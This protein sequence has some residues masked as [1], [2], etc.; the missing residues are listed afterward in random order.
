MNKNHLLIYFSNLKAQSPWL[1]ALL[2]LFCPPTHA[3]KHVSKDTASVVLARIPTQRKLDEA[4]KNTDYQYG[5]DIQIGETWWD[6]LQRKFWQWVASFFGDP[7]YGEI[8]RWLAILFLAGMAVFIILKLLGVNIVGLTGK[9]GST[10]DIPYEAFGENIHAINYQE[11][12]ENAIS[13]KNYRLAVRLYYLKTLKE[14]TDKGMIEWK[15]NK[16]NRTYLVELNKANLKPA[17]EQIT[18]Q[19]EYAWYGD[20]PIDE[21]RFTIIREDFLNFGK[22]I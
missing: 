18:Q 5:Q 19:F 10:L 13:Q 21:P 22:T 12:I 9:K 3:Q 4:K 20:F 11:A 7:R 2:L 16:T 1:I 14:L 8:R 6:R 17:F 15:V